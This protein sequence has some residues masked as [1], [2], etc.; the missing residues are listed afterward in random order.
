VS[1][2]LHVPLDSKG[3]W[4]GVAKR[5]PKPRD[6]HPPT[7]PSPDLRTEQQATPTATSEAASRVNEKK[8]GKRIKEKQ[9]KINVTHDNNN[10]KK[11]IN[12]NA[13]KSS[14]RSRGAKTEAKPTTTK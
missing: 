3:V 7:R 9:T 14:N 1:K 8:H 5:F 10:N 13:S 11:N 6:S 4:T 2:L 12:D